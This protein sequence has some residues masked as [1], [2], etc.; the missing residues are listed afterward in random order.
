MLELNNV[1][2]V[3]ANSKDPVLGLAALE[4]CCRYVRFSAVKLLSHIKPDSFPDWAEFVQIQNLATMDDYNWFCITELHKHI[5]TPLSLVTQTD[6]FIIHPEFWSDAFLDYDYIGAVWPSHIRGMRQGQPVGNSGFCMRSKRLLEAT[7]QI[8]AR[9]GKPRRCKDDLFACATHYPE[10]VEMGMKFAP[11]EIASRF[12]FE[13]PVAG[14]SLTE[15][16]T[17]GFHGKRTPGTRELC[18]SLLQP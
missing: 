15:R 11:V 12:S 1:T 2:L 17:F 5:Q 10:L 7:S 3:T 8:A 9:V 16:D 14:L 18:A 6:G 13:M 4:R